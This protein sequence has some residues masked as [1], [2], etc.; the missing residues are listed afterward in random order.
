MKN[1][2]QNQHIQ[3]K[4]I[5]REICILC[6]K[7]LTRDTQQRIN[8]YLWVVGLE[9]VY[10]SFHVICFP[11]C[12]CVCVCVCVCSHQTCITF[13]IKVQMSVQKEDLAEGSDTLRRWYK[14]YTV[15]PFL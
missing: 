6:M 12:V 2:T 13:V 4:S 3:Y 14:I 1:Q 10:F 11:A 7:T 15:Q 9:V 5:F 8:S